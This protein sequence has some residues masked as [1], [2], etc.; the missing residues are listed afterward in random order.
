[1][2]GSQKKEQHFYDALRQ[3]LPLTL[4]REILLLT[5]DRKDVLKS[6]GQHHANT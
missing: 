5:I 4:D 2:G 3:C 6:V 1:M